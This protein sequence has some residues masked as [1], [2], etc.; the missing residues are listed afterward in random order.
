VLDTSFFHFLFIRKKEMS[1]EHRFK[2]AAHFVAKSPPN[3][4]IGNAEK[5]ETYALYKQATIGDVQGGQPWAVQLE[6][7]AKW[8]AWNSQKGISKEDA[9]KAYIERV[10]K[11]DPKWETSEIAASFKE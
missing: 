8:D 5:L 10:E 3:P 2:K 7:R 11:G 1:L 9:M 4:E 6:A